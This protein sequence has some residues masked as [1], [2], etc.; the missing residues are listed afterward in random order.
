MEE[1][2]YVEPVRKKIDNLYNMT[3]C[4]DDYINPTAYRMLSWISIS[5]CALDLE[6]KLEKC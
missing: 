2:R 6:E 4:M 1:R 3:T 5:S